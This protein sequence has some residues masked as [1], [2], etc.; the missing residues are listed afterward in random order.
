[1]FV[2]LVTLKVSLLGNN[3]DGVI[4]RETAEFVCYGVVLFEIR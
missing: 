2:L 3:V 1:M 4:I